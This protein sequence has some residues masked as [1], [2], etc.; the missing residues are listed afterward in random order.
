VKLVSFR[1]KRILDFLIVTLIFIILGV[2]S[3]VGARLPTVGGDT[4]VWGTILNSFLLVEHAENGTHTNVTATGLNVSDGITPKLVIDSSNNVAIGITSPGFKLDVNGV[5]NST[6]ILINE[7]TCTN[8]LVTDSSGL[9]FCSSTDLGGAGDLSNYAVINTS[10]QIFQGIVHFSGNISFGDNLTVG[11]DKFFVDSSSGRVG[12]GTTL[13]IFK[14]DVYGVINSTSILI[15]ETTC[16]NG[17]VTDGTGLIYCSSTALGGGAG[18]LSNY[19]TN[20][21][22]NSFTGLQNLTGGIFLG[23]T[24]ITDNGTIRWTGSDFQGYN[25]TQWV[26]LTTRAEGGI[27]PAFNAHKNGVGQVLQDSTW[28][29]L[30]FTHEDF[31][32]NDDFD[33]TNWWFKPSVPGKY[34]LTAQIRFGLFSQYVR[35]EMAI[36]KNGAKVTDDFIDTDFVQPTFSTLRITQIYDAD[37]VNDY[38][39]VYAYHEEGSEMG[40][41]GTSDDTYFSGVRIDGGGN[42]LWTQSNPYI[43]YVTGDVGIGTVTPQQRLDVDGNFSVDNATLFVDDVNRRVGIGTETPSMKLDID[44]DANVTGVTYLGNSTFSVNE[45]DVE[46]SGNV[47]ISAD[48]LLRLNANTTEII[49]DS[50]NDGSIIYS[51]PK[52]YGC[53]GSDW[54]AL[55]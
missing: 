51:S 39:E 46:I 49:C 9:I 19:A 20:N 54:L 24:S 14:L 50:S 4:D 18:D 13:P 32:T 12:I 29:K 6:S 38:F 2:F 17:L 26:S 44:G 15:N 3:V 53:N 22:S 43:Y 33:T 10:M 55:Y 41:R 7:T 52:H 5:I 45:T 23:N 1:K 35:V 28:T 31:D 11:G 42:G 40:V 30:N 27:S 8:G 21:E 36:Y 48:E 34:L 47:T 25:G 16:T 37:G